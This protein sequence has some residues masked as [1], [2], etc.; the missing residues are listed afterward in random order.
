MRRDDV[1]ENIF[2]REN[3]FSL[4]FS[5]VLGVIH[6]KFRDL[7]RMEMEKDRFCAIGAYE[8]IRHRRGY[9]F[10]LL[11]SAATSLVFR[12]YHVHIYIQLSGSS[13]L[14]STTTIMPPRYVHPFLPILHLPPPCRHLLTPLLLSRSATHITEGRANRAARGPGKRLGAKKSALELVVPGNIIFRQRGTHW[15]PGENCGMGR[16]HTIFAKEKGYVTYYKDEEKHPDRKYIGIVFER[17]MTLPRG[18]HEPRRRRLG[19][20]GRQRQMGTLARKDAEEVV[21]G[22]GTPMAATAS[23]GRAETMAIVTVPPHLTVVK[24]VPPTSKKGYMYRPSN[25]EI[26]QAAEK[27]NI[28]VPIYRKGNRFEALKKRKAKR[29]AWL[30]KRVL[31]GAKGKGK[32][33]KK[34]GRR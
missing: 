16:D 1:E 20:V 9:F 23:E 8:W 15:F 25:W 21:E 19:F 18:R 31:M 17:H 7:V 29:A 4:L 34:K 14:R 22:V 33:K 26:G 13:S 27:A 28:T 6:T 10:S 11:L 12:I 30:E 32:K 24:W 3:R 5:P 2:V